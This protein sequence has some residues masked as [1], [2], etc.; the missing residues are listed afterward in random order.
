MNCTDVQ[1]RL[2]EFH[3]LELASRKR[4]QVQGHLVRCPVCA[5]VLTSYQ[6]LTRLCRRLPALVPD[7]ELWPRIEAALQSRRDPPLVDRRRRWISSSIAVVSIAAAVLVLLGVTFLPR[8]D[9]SPSHSSADRHLAVNFGGFLDQFSRDPHIAQKGLLRNFSGKSINSADA[10]RLVGY[11]PSALKTPPQGYLLQNVYVLKMPCCV[12]IEAVYRR[13]D[14]KLLAI[15]E[16]AEEQPIWFGERPRIEAHCNDKPT[17]IVQLED[18][19]AVSWKQD[20]RHITV[21]GVRDVEE[22]TQLMAHLAGVRDG[23]G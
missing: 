15:F 23:I 6:K 3:D 5:D 16:H 4:A 18:Q 10:I 17:S 7:T 13:D 1:E 12:C 8:G 22:V 9:E 2:S 21:V 20:R 14:G 19:L 11:Q